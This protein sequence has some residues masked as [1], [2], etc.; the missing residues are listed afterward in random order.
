MLNPPCSIEDPTAGLWLISFGWSCYVFFFFLNTDE[1]CGYDAVCNVCLTLLSF[2]WFCTEF[3]KDWILHDFTV[4][5]IIMSLI[6]LRKKLKLKSS[7]LS[8]SLATR[9]EIWC[10][11]CCISSKDGGVLQKA[12]VC[13]SC[14]LLEF[15]KKWLVKSAVL[16]SEDTIHMKAIT[17][18][19]LVMFWTDFI[20][21]VSWTGVGQA[22]IN[23][24]D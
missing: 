17:F 1:A 11:W 5:M 3:L 15:V 4:F 2:R 12:F 19:I 16:M 13:C 20:D 6:L 7:T 23:I 9:E 24:Y 8:S 21:T 10:N 18:S 14:Y 22:A